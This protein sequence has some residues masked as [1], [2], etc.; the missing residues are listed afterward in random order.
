M[1]RDA[2]VELA[3]RVLHAS[4]SCAGCVAE[5][6]KGDQAIDEVA[7]IGSQECRVNCLCEILYRKVA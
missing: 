3:R 4:E 6:A 7:P 5:A 1:Q 2:G